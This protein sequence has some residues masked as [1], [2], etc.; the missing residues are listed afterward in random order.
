MVR[1][2]SLNHAEYEEKQDSTTGLTQ[3]GNREIVGHWFRKP[4]HSWGND[5]C[6]VAHE[7]NTGNGNKWDKPSEFGLRTTRRFAGVLYSQPGGKF[8]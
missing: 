2:D 7:Y 1:Q 4:I 8:S 6:R 5:P 3:G